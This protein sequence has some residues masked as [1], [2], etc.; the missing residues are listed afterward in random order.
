MVEGPRAR[1]PTVEGP[2]APL[3]VGQW[4]S[5]HSPIRSARRCFAAVSLM[6]L[7]ERGAQVAAQLPE[8]LGFL[9]C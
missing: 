5:L 3:L 7:G 9:Q 6:E 2:R 8:D 1:P 4:L